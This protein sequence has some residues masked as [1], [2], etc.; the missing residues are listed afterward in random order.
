MCGFEEACGARVL[1][2]ACD[3]RAVGEGFGACVFVGTGVFAAAGS[4]SLIVAL[5]CPTPIGPDASDA[6]RANHSL[7]SLS[8]SPLT[9][10][11]TWTGSPFPGTMMSPCVAT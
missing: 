6:L 3:G 1:T 11:V 2:G 9:V 10:T 5:L 4:S 7:L 8:V